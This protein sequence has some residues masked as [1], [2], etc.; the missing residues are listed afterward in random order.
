MQ[1]ISDL[2]TYLKSG[3]L[4]KDKPGLDQI[5]EILESIQKADLA[6]SPTHILSTPHY[7]GAMARLKMLG[8]TSPYFDTVK[9]PDG[10]YGFILA[11]PIVAG[12]ETSVYLSNLRGMIRAV[13]MTSEKFLFLP[14]L[15]TLQR[16]IQ[17][18]PLSQKYALAFLILSPSQD[19]LQLLCCG[20]GSILHLSAGSRQSR[21]L[22]NLNPPLG[23]DHRIEWDIT[24]D[25]W[26]IGDILIFHTLPTAVDAILQ[27]TLDNIALQSPQ[28][29]ADSLI[30]KS[31][32]A[33]TE[34]KPHA[35]ISLHRIG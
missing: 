16:L 1:L 35:L 29:Q 9:F 28:S 26:G 31:V 32:A 27:E 33:L 3:G 24:S 34:K 14:F 25:S 12:L 23:S 11:E 2:S 5:K 22:H 20:M 19:Q 13:A 30:K 10:S 6:L 4:D 18:D 15:L 17:L 7:E 21:K 8:Q